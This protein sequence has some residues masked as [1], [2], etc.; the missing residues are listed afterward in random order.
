[1]NAALEGGEWSAARPGRTLPPGKDP[2][3]TLQEAGWA[4]GLVWTGGKSHPHR[5]SIP[6]RPVRRLQI[7][8]FSKLPLYISVYTLYTI[9][10]DYKNSTFCPQRVFMCFV[11]IS[12]PTAIISLYNINWSVFTTQAQC[13]Y[14][15]V[16]TGSLYIL[17]RSAHRVYLCVFYGSQN[18]QRL[19]PSTTL[20]DRFLQPRHSVFTALLPFHTNGR[21]IS[22]AKNCV[23]ALRGRI[24]RGTEKISCWGGS[25]L[26]VQS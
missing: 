10:F 14:C 11:W 13:V 18:Q 7:I 1:M 23:W 19:F 24:K 12:E 20:T 21:Y 22:K 9:K 26:T 16:R 6:D 5:D 4:P 2:I 8:S 17:L 15:A 25:E 3:P